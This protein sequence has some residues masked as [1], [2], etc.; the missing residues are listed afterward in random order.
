[1]NAYDGFTDASGQAGARLLVVEDDDATRDTLTGGLRLYGHTVSSAA[2]CHGAR[3]LL[4][5]GIYDAILLDVNLPDET[6]FALLREVRD[7]SRRGGCAGPEPAVMV[8]SGR[9]GEIDR[10][11]GFELGC[12]DYLVKPYSFG[13]LRGRLEAVLR[14]SRGYG[15]GS[16]QQI[17]ELAIDHRERR[18]ELNGT[19]VRLTAKEWA[20]LAVLASDP[21]RVFTREYLL[22]TVWGFRTG[23]TT[24][25]L[26]AHAC[27]LRAKLASG[28]R[29]YV[30]NRWG[31]G[32]RLFDPPEPKSG[33]AAE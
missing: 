29:R 26:D 23:G 21:A 12:D 4:R 28:S 25:T 19:S 32:Y 18:V 3:R 10:V 20:L 1:M 16:V 24:R 7:A 15:A 33:R 17:G 8:I 6:G 9:A 2:D 27:R 14:R 30:V 31:V 22:N 13:E 11:R 5:R